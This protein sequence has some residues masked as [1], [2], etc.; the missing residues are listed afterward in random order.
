MPVRLE[1]RLFTIHEAMC[2]PNMYQYWKCTMAFNRF[3]ATIGE[4]IDH[5]DANRSN[6]HRLKGKKDFDQYLRSRLDCDNTGLATETLSHVSTR[7]DSCVD[8]TSH[9]GR[10][11]RNEHVKCKRND[12]RFI[13]PRTFAARCIENVH[14]VAVAHSC[15]N[16]QLEN[17]VLLVLL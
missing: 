17:F 6:R 5:H 2:R 15:S 1:N 7:L 4:N 3:S 9:E 10:V 11:T 12:Y 14:G 13:C 8:V 16:I